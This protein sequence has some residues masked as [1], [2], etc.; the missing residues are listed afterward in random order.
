MPNAYS[1][2]AE[3]KKRLAAG[4]TAAFVTPII[5]DVEDFVWE[6]VFHYVKGIKLYDPYTVGRTK[7]LFDA[8]GPG[9]CSWS[10]KTLVW[11]S[12]EVGSKFEFVIQRAD[13]FKKAELLGFSELS[14]QSSAA[15]LGAAL[16]RHWN[17]KFDID[18]EA[19]KVKDPR[20]A[21]LL[22]QRDRKRFT[23]IETPYERLNEKE[24]T[25]KWTETKEGTEGAG[26]QGTKNGAVR[27][28]WYFGQKQ[29]FEVCTI[30]AEAYTFTLDWARMSLPDFVTL[31]SSPSR[32]SLAKA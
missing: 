18:S 1:L 20:L 21:V 27:L 22:K 32:T 30:P 10:L 17:A 4:L 6:A 28:K 3:E 19:Q 12:L 2:S 13:I 16:I 7:Q 8:V 31:L 23:Y 5:D 11:P 25:W 29:L 24:F 14:R 9:G 26:L 15:D